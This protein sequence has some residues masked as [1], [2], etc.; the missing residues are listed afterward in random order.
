M[1]NG[2]TGSDLDLRSDPDN[3]K[4][5]KIQTFDENLIRRDDGRDKY[6]TRKERVMGFEMI[7][8]YPHST[9]RT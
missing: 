7:G 1:I 4:G 3:Q 6:I 9:K 8:R 2:E 5:L